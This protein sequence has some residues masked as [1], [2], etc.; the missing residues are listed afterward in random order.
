VR[1]RW[2]LT[3]CST[4]AELLTSYWRRFDNDPRDLNENKRPPLYGG[5]LFFHTYRR[6]DAD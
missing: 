3:F 5:F 1:M 6:F 2:I 4:R